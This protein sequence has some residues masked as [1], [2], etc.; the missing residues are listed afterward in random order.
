[1]NYFIVEQGVFE[2]HSHSYGSR[3]QRSYTRK[4][5]FFNLL[6]RF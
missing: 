5:S 2:K 4:E 6:I 3:K 1:M